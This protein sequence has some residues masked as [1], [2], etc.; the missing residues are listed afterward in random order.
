M[1]SLP[2]VDYDVWTAAEVAAW[3]RGRRRLPS[4]LFQDE[5]DGIDACA[6]AVIND[7]VARLAPSGTFCS[8]GP[9]RPHFRTG[10]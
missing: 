9:R 7:E 4:E 1:P 6:V 5:V 3:R 10:K 8:T 2:R